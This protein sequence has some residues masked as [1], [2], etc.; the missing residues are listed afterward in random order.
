MSE[1]SPIL[2]EARGCEISWPG[3]PKGFRVERIQNGVHNAVGLRFLG[4]HEIV[5][6][7]VGGDALLFLAG[8]LGEQIDELFLLPLH[9]L[10]IDPDG[11][12][13]TLEASGTLMDHYLGIRR[14]VPLSGG[15]GGQNHRRHGCRHP[16]ADRA[17]RGLDALHRVDDGQ[18]GSDVSAWGID[19]EVDGQFVI[20]RIQ[21]EEFRN[22]PAGGFPGDFLAE[23]ENPM[24]QKRGGQ[25]I[26]VFAENAVRLTTPPQS[27]IPVIGR[28]WADAGSTN[29]A[30][31]SLLNLFNK[32][33]NA[34]GS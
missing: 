18:A 30:P 7:D 23:E 15:P 29:Q 5:V 22:H 34:I 25:N 28:V 16:D 4:G 13:L 6:L 24:L 9:P 20:V 14:G 11:A 32:G 17:D 26:H 21:Q 3:L 31:M 8:P 10:G 33:G 12:G 19:V 1:G 2:Q 27:K